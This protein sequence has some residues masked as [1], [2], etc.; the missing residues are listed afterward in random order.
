MIPA[1]LAN[2]QLDKVFAVN[3]S[4]VDQSIQES[5]LDEHIVDSKIKRISGFVTAAFGAEENAAKEFFTVENPTKTPFSLLQIDNG[6]IKKNVGPATKKCDCAIA[7]NSS[8]CF[9]EFKTKASS[10]IISTIEKNYRRAI[11]Q[12]TATIGIFDSYHKSQGVDFRSLRAVKAYICFRHG[13][14]RR[15]SS[16]M[17]YQ[18]SF[19]KANNGIPL[20]FD[21]KKV[22]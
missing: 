3:C 17:N 20:S 5:T 19:A 2:L 21:R 11:E 18:V 8:L 12:L 1:Y 6:I 9:I 16:Q 22:L 15:T 7:N 4:N 13:Y 10:N 14:P